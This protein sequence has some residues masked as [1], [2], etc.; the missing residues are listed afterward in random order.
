MNYIN[1]LVSII[2]RT[3]S[4]KRINLLEQAIK[5]I[6]AND[7]RPIEIIIIVQSQE[8]NFIEKV[9][10]LASNYI[11]KQVFCIVKLNQ[12][13]NDERAKNLNLGIQVAKGRFIGFLDDDDVIYPNH[14]SS[15]INLLNQSKETAWA[16]SDVAAAI[17]R[18]QFEDNLEIISIDYPFVKAA[19]SKITLW[20]YNFIPIHSYLLDSAKIDRKLLEFDESFQ[21]LEDYAFLLKIVTRYQPIYLPKVTCEYRFFQD[22]NNSNFYADYTLGLCDYKKLALWQKHYQKIEKLKKQLMS[23]YHSGLLPIYARQL[24]LARFPLL[25]KL[26]QTFPKLWNLIAQFIKKNKFIQS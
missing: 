7:Y 21:V 9:K 19:F 22:V 14:L 12:T 13:S 17:C 6:L 15:L 1:N 25:F 8:I 4:F 20:Q 16:Y 18:S 2:I 5:S 10:E 26:K 3:N 23:T 11:Q 24:I